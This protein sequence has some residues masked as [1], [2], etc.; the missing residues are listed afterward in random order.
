[1]NPVD[2]SIEA[3]VKEK[4]DNLTKPKGALGLLEELACTTTLNHTELE[5]D[6]INSP[7]SKN[8]IEMSAIA[9]RPPFSLR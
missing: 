6:L 2:R 3:T 4:I 1:M 8:T 7:V 9:V 5:I